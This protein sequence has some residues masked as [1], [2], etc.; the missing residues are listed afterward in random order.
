LTYIGDNLMF[1]HENLVKMLNLTFK[2]SEA[3]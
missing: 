2:G 1:M 3:T